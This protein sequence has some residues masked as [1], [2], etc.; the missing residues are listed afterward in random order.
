MLFLPQITVPALQP[1]KPA[2]AHKNAPL[3]FFAFTILPMATMYAPMR[4]VALFSADFVQTSLKARIMTFFSVR[5]TSSS[6][7]VSDC[8]FEGVLV[9]TKFM[10]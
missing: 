2:A 6:S 9:R 4:S 3:I 5:F 1:G 8:I 10:V 7:Q